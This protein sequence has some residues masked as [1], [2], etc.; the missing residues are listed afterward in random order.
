MLQD[1]NQFEKVA[2]DKILGEG[3]FS[4]ISRVRYRQNGKFYALKQVN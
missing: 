4:K 2:H 3:Q 1:L